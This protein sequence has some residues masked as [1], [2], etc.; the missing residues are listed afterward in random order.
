MAIKSPPRPQPSRAAKDVYAA[1]PRSAPPARNN[2]TVKETIESI[3]IAFILAFVFRAYVVEAFVIP[4][5][6]MAPTLL[7]RNLRVQCAQCG[8]R[9]HVDPDDT[10]LT[11]NKIRLAVSISA[12]CPMC[13]YRNDLHP[14][15]RVSAG[16]RILVH[17]YIYS[18]TDPRR[19]DVVVFKTPRQPGQNYIKRL[20]GLPN[21][22]LWIIEGNVY[23]RSRAGPWQIARKTERPRVQRDVFQPI[24]HSWYIPLDRGPNRRK[25]QWE[26]TG[27]TAGQ[28]KT[29]NRRSYVYR[30]LDAGT[31]QFRFPNLTGL[32]WYPYN[33]LRGDMYRTEPIEDI[34]LAVGVEPEAPGL[35]LV[36]RTTARLRHTDLDPSR[37]TVIATIDDQGTA[38]LAYHDPRTG[39]T[40]LA[41][42]KAQVGP[43]VPGRT[44][45]VELWHV[46]Q[47][48]SLWVDGK[49]VLD[50]PYELDIRVLQQR[51]PING[52][53][54]FPQVSLTVSG[55]AVALHRVE[56]DRDLYY[57]S[58]KSRSSHSGHGTLAK[59]HEHRT[60]TGHAI[61]LTS[62]QFYC[63]GDNSPMSDDSRYWGHP[64][65][66]IRKSMLSDDAE[67][68]GIVPRPLMMGRA[69]FV[70][71]P[72]AWSWNDQLLPVVPNFAEMRFIH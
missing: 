8:Y 4:T 42:Q 26:A 27:M 25:L 33:Q 41:P 1:E 13:R 20:V 66:W 29:Q 24:Y 67:P 45:R 44:R 72:A 48:I 21:E 40:K 46:D 43:F 70:Y 50:D 18:L 9:F 58:S 35:K 12:R 36:L 55:A 60:A 47:E 10:S 56:L 57:S 52:P 54:L 61:D 30:G 71:F 51:A 49:R 3:V 14:E 38:T 11:A 16:D 34:R 5:G 28:W 64:D 62:D 17:K 6:S 69:F 22:K 65:P 32:H 53:D 19:W 63:L 2:E 15:I 37:Q 7:G 68:S 31:I 39:R 23:V 59:A